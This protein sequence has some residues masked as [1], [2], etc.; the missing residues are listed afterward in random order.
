MPA[1]EHHDD[2]PPTA[3]DAEVQQLREQCGHQPPADGLGNE[4]N[5]AADGVPDP[6]AE[7]AAAKDQVLR[8]QAEMD[9]LR[10]RT[11]KEIQTERQYGA[12]GLMRELLPVVDN[13]DRAIEAA[14]QTSDAEGLL[15]GFRLVQQQLM[16]VLDHHHCQLIDAEGEV[17]NPDFHE[18]ILQ[19]P[20]AEHPAHSVVMVTQTGYKLHDRVI[21]PAQVIVSSG[22]PAE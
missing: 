22:P 4:L 2:L 14:Q 6:A 3:D 16:T 8:L 17:F 5:E 1:D 12:M 18:A 15:E 13:I 9:N 19:Q 10:K 11:S 21:R 7:L 20:S